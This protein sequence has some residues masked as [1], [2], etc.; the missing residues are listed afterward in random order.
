MTINE[1]PGFHRRNRH[2]FEYDFRK[3]IEVCP[4]LEQYIEVNNFETETINFAVHDAVK[5]L[6]KA[7]LK[8]HYNIINWEIPPHYLCPPVPGR[9]DYI[10]HIADLIGAQKKQVKVLDIGVGANCIY[11]IIGVSEYGWN[12]VGSDIDSTAIKSANRILAE[13]PLIHNNVDLRLQ[14]D[15]SNIFSNIITPAERF[16]ASICNPPFHDSFKQAKDRNERKLR[17]LNTNNSPGNKLNFGGKPSELICSGGEAEFIR[18]M[19]KQS[20]ELPD[21]IYWYSSLVS[22]K[23]NLPKIYRQIKRSG[24]RQ[25]ETIEMLHGQKQSRIIAWSFY[26]EKAKRQF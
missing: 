12:F 5:T 18:R 15:K 23:D 1:K 17:N 9:A 6:N 26:S 16:N 4:E 14:I 3:L 7:I 21:R 11:P 19:I 25:L 2:R 13:N 22:N 24:A 8:L 10:H 20:S